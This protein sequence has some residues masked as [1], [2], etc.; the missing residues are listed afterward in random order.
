MSIQMYFILEERGKLK[1]KLDD[2]NSRFSVLIKENADIQSEIEYFSYPE[3][4]EKE[5]RQKFNYK[6]PGEK[7]IIIIP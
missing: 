3:N 1:I 6:K 4:L 2:L 5:L 7:M